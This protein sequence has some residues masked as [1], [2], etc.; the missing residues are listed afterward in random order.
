MNLYRPKISSWLRA[1]QLKA[2]NLNNLDRIFELMVK[3]LN[4][5]NALTVAFAQAGDF[6]GG[7]DGCYKKKVLR[8][9]MNSFF[10]DVDK[11]FKFYGR[12]NE[13][14]TTYCLLGQ[15]GKLMLTITDVALVQKQTQTND[16]GMTGIYLD[17]GTYLK[18]FYSVMFCPSCVKVSTMG[19]THKRIHHKIS[20][21]NCT[22]KIINQKY[23]K[24]VKN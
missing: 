9:V 22:P 16:G 4:D 14:V 1:R 13:D 18:T 6:I 23:K 10:C 11:P 19:S 8:K 24:E 2:K 5:T 15:R 20:W 3:F 7:V 21:N 17:N 12:I